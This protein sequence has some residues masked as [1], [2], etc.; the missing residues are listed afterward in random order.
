M[1]KIVEIEEPERNSNSKI[2]ALVIEDN[3]G[4]IWRVNFKAELWFKAREVNL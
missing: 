2:F 1:A 4:N 3:S